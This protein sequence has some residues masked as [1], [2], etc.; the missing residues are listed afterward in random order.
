M[1]TLIGLALI[2]VFTG[3]ARFIVTKGDTKIT[4]HNKQYKVIKAGNQY[5]MAENLATDS[6]RSGKK[7]P[8][9]SDYHIWPEMNTPGCGYYDNDT[10]NLSRYGM[11][12]NWY[13]VDAG[14]L[15]PAGWRVPTH[16][17]WNKLEETLGGQSNAG[18]KMKSVSGW[19]GNH[20]SG[21]DIGFNALPGGYRLNNDF[22][23]GKEAIWWSSTKADTRYFQKVQINDAYKD[24]VGSNT[25]VWGRKIRNVSSD[26]SSTLNLR[27]N[28]FAVRCVNAK[29]EKKM[30]GPPASELKTEK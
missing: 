12:Y 11:L 16:E 9:I 26:L 14:K 1:K 3:C 22:L 17:D 5:W 18:A 30:T 7:I 13:A 6:Y 10:A 24:L 8:L 28:G 27:N 20:V 21:D 25:Y 4:Y 15:C 29:K 23:A 19:E 2:L